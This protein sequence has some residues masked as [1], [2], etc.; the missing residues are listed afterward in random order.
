[1]RL[2]LAVHDTR[3]CSPPGQVGPHAYLVVRDEE[4]RLRA[5]YNLCRHRAM[6]LV[7]GEQGKAC[8]V[9]TVEV[10]HDGVAF[11][12][13]TLSL[14]LVCEYHGWE[15]KLDGRLSK[16]VGLKGIKNFRAMDYGLIE[17][18]LKVWGPLVMLNFGGSRADETGGALPPIRDAYAG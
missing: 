11:L 7:H 15:Y 16:A 10:R 2:P 5:F 13:L 12:I 1:V 17:I 8:K 18:P 3:S 4:G 14:K 6:G 9:S